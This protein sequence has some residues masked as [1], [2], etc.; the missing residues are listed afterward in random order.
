MKLESD[1]VAQQAIAVGAIN[2]LQPP[3]YRGALQRATNG[4]WIGETARQSPDTSIFGYPP[5]YAPSLHSPLLQDRNGRQYTAYYEV[6]IPASNRREVS[7]AMG[8]A[9]MPY[10]PFRL[11]GWHRGS[12][13]V[14]GDDGRRYVN[15]TWGGKDFTAPLAPG[16]TYGIGIRFSPS[17]I[18]HEISA[19]VFFTVD[20][21]LDGGWDVNEETDAER[22][23]PV[24]GLQGHHDLSI[25][26]GTFEVVKF[27][28]RLRPS[29]WLYTEMQ[30]E[31][32]AE[33]QY[34]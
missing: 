11:P 2:L 18:A 28:V 23:R 7:L 16:K 27:E 12:L 10:P 8:F 29:Q 13:A 31:R 33:G 20:G 21:R 1:L 9:A 14:H 5:L 32:Q 26:I 24:V 19:D 4:T 6:H 34:F 3:R 15:D 30:Q 17:D 22:D 25:A